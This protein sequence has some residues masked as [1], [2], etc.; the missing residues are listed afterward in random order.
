VRRRAFVAHPRHPVTGR[1]FRVSATSARKLAALLDLVDQYREELRLGARSSADVARQLRRLSRGAVSVARVVD[2]YA[3]RDDLSPHT[4]RRVRGWL[5]GPGRELRDRELDDLDGPSC[6]RW[7]A[8]VRRQAAPSSTD[9]AWR[10]LRALVRFAAER[11]LVDRSPWGAWRPSTRAAS[12]APVR[13]LREC[14]RTAGELGRLLMSAE[15]ISDELA[16]KVAVAAGLGLRDSELARLTW[17]DLEADVGIV[18]VRGSKGT[19][20]ARLV[21]PAG[22]WHRLDAH[23][24]AMQLAGLYATRGPVFPSRATSTPGK[25]RAAARCLS[26]RELR[27]AVDGAGLPHPERWSPHSLRDTFA[28]LE[29]AACGDLAALMARTRHA[30]I[31]SLVRYLRPRERDPLR[32]PA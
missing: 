13:E 10:T 2:L 27:A 4:R 3:A 16:T 19:P 5:A 18:S 30:S 29:H 23:R 28:T 14:C 32:L 11:G 12:H 24:A 31:G 9:L 15:R 7:L 6:A 21:A 8:G 1:Q 22:V 17:N 20:A 25:P 26:S